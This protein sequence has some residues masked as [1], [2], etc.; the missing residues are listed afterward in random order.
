MNRWNS[1]AVILL[2][3]LVA[4]AAV[5]LYARHEDSLPPGNL[6]AGEKLSLADQGS[7]APPALGEAGGRLEKPEPADKNPE[8]LY[9]LNTLP[10]PVKRTV[11]A[12]AEAAASGDIERMRAVLEQNELKPMVSPTNVEDPIE[13]WK[14]ASADGMGREVLAAML[15]VL[16]SGFVHVGKGQNELYVWPYF[17]E[18]NLALL[19]P[20]QEVELYRIMSPSIAVSMKQSGKYSYYRLG[21]SPEGVWHYFLQ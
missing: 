5:L 13:Y 7:N 16:A 11:N 19:T 10:D 4:G 8:V 9:D 6:Q 1:F 21:I 3:A 14:K 17:A 12:I 15:N 20:A 2:A 18:S